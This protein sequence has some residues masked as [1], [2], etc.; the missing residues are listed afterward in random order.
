MSVIRAITNIP[1][2]VVCVLYSVH[3]IIL[4]AC[5]GMFVLRAVAVCSC[6][7]L[8]VFRSCGLSDVL[9]Y[10]QWCAEGGATAPGIQPGASSPGHPTREF[11]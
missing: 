3:G 4:F 8:E 2:C 6:K 5:L 7:L 9:R 11:S 10:S 1:V